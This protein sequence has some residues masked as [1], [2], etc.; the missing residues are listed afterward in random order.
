MS[1]KR[2]FLFIV[3]FL[4]ISIST[5]FFT[6]LF[7]PKYIES[8]LF[9]EIADQT[10]LQT[11]Q[12]EIRRIGLTG[13]DVENIALG[14]PGSPFLSAASL[15]IDYSV[16]VLWNRHIEMSLDGLV[17]DCSFTDG[18]FVLPGFSPPAGR[19]KGPPSETPRL[20]FSLGRL[21][22]KNGLLNFRY[23]GHLLKIP[24][25][26]QAEQS[27]P[28]KFQGRLILFT[29]DQEL[30][31]LTDIDLNGNRASINLSAVSFSLQRFADIIGLPAG[32]TI[33]GNLDIESSGTI[34][35][36]PFQLREISTSIKSRDLSLLAET[37]SLQ[38]TAADPLT[39]G[40][41]GT[42]H[43][44]HLT[45]NN[46]QVN[47]ASIKFAGKTD[48]DLSVA[49]QELLG[50]GRLS[51]TLSLPEEYKGSIALPGP[52]DIGLDF[53]AEK[54]K[55]SWQFSVTDNMQSSHVVNL[56]LGT[57]L[58]SI[59]RP[60]ITLS[61]AGNSQS[62]T[63]RHTFATPDIRILQE[64]TIKAGSQFK[65]T[66]QVNLHGERNLLESISGTLTVDM[67]DT[68]V[69][70][71][72]ITTKGSLSITGTYSA[73]K[74]TPFSID[75]TSHIVDTSITD[76][77]H[78]IV[79]NKVNGKVP[80][81][82]PLDRSSAKETILADSIIWKDKAVGSMEASFQ[83]HG[84]MLQIEG[85][86]E[87]KLLPGLRINF[88]GAYQPAVSGQR[89]G[90]TL[91]FDMPEYVAQS[92]DLSE[93]RPMP[94]LIF[95]DG[96][97]RM[98]GKISGTF[99]Q[100]RGTVQ[101]QVTDGLVEIPGQDMAMEGIRTSLTLP[102]L[103]PPR[104]A[105]AQL[106]SFD[107]LTIGDLSVTNGAVTFQLESPDV[108]FIEKSSVQ[109]GSGRL[110]TYNLR[111]TSTTGKEYNVN[112]YAE[113]LSLGEILEQFGLSYAG[114]EGRVNGRISLRLK[115]REIDIHDSFLYS[116]PGRGGTLKLSNTDV[117]TQGMPGDTPGFSQLDFAAEALREFK[118]D[119]VKLNFVNEGEELIMKM[120]MDGKPDRR[121]PFRYDNQSGAFVRLQGN[122]PAAGIYQ[123]IRLDVNFR[124][125]LNT[126]LEYK[127]GIDEL[128]NS[129][130]E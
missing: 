3:I 101:L 48:I 82:W 35:L 91:L 37:F 21:T 51:G 53:T 14:S 114:G 108:L 44:L 112:L 107:S 46:F 98:Q 36:T 60:R 106:F 12:A 81:V 75:L 104:S 116:T 85:S 9:P 113:Q 92:L 40:I 6:S 117:I 38:N 99:S 64:K 103:L 8:H 15:T 31:V 59:K 86:H 24:F 63:I 58:L 10:G 126:I 30:I 22:I 19:Q 123:P 32:M 110:N 34:Q 2:G 97:F 23:N 67:K 78:E 49:E 50:T 55:E 128:I 13:I 89:E 61:G 29:R 27:G 127:N 73:D 42:P 71:S 18:R 80:F 124:L 4:A 25:D 122:D 102:D 90:F 26:L 62:A 105:P 121:L 28:Q 87:N 95:V 66:G 109:W 72:G 96:R 43:K 39:I 77:Q 119:W 57:A 52:V 33:T 7:L 47:S 120:Q 115:D 20:P 129:F 130:T 118:Y 1:I 16:G 17:L 54:L 74:N 45:M 41:D 65:M 79:I 100:P 68:A 125:P 84:S 5:L 94:E 111:L 69:F 56:Q 76:P 88:S 83:Q 11:I 93:I 70:A